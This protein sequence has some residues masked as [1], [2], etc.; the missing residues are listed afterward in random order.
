[1]GAFHW[2]N[3][4]I[5]R[6]QLPENRRS[7]PTVALQAGVVILWKLDDGEFCLVHGAESRR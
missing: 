2:G 5:Q 7:F 3:S 4:G 1:M 6:H